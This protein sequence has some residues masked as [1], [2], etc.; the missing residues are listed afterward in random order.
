M[1]LADPIIGLADPNSRV[2]FGRRDR[3]G[4][5]TAYFLQYIIAN[6]YHTFICKRMK[7]CGIIDN[8]KD[9]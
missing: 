6:I 4:V 3:S 5:T 9:H 1:G 2:I 8:Y 7:L